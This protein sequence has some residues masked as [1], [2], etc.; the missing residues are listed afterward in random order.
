MQKLRNSVCDYETFIRDLSAMI[1]EMMGKEYSAKIY[2]VINN[3]SQENDSMVLLKSGSSFAHSMQL[4]QYYEEYTKGA[5]MLELAGRLC[6]IYHNYEKEQTADSF[7]YTFENI[8]NRIIYRLVSYEKNRKMLEK[9]PYIKYLDLAITYQCLIHNDESK[10]AAI[11]IT[12]EHL[13]SWKISVNE[14]HKLAAD[15]TKRE[16]PPVFFC[17]DEIIHSTYAQ[18][19][20]NIFYKE[21]EISQDIRHSCNDDKKKMY[22]LSNSIGINGASCLLYNNVLKNFSAKVQAD[23][24]IL[25]SSIHEVILMPCNSSIDIEELNR[26]VRNINRT[27]LD[28]DEVLSD[29]VYYY[30]REYDAIMQ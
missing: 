21:K 10:F 9:V 27:Q 3:N 13:K 15:N 20:H 26:V 19:K 18:G 4:L 24:Y 2:K 8:K 29:R 5:D 14:L 22:V 1:Q 23:V 16:F 30:S 6:A 7:T 28:Y 12:N 25:P 11:R 17:M